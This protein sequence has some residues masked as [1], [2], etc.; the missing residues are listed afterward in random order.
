MS[1][2]MGQ[3]LSSSGF[4]SVLSGV[5]QCGLGSS[6]ALIARSG[7]W[8]AGAL[9][10]S[11]PTAGMCDAWGVDETSSSGLVAPSAL[12]PRKKGFRNRNARKRP[13]SGKRVRPFKPQAFWC[14]LPQ[15]PSTKFNTSCSWRKALI[16][17]YYRKTRQN[18]LTMTYTQGYHRSGTKN[19][20]GWG[21]FDFII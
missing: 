13:R 17:T 21:K 14:I 18:G 6:G 3:W 2:I 12:L 7:G 8:S 9:T 20:D 19:K 10:S 16:V 11:S 1:L 15:V 4:F 5:E